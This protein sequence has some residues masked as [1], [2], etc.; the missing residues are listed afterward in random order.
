MKNEGE[1]V[2][3][4]IV[5]MVSFI[6]HVAKCQREPQGTRGLGVQGLRGWVWF[7]ERGTRTV[8]GG[9]MSAVDRRQGGRVLG[10]SLDSMLSV[11][12]K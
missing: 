2:L 4:Q 5:S 1:S 7:V 3:G 6:K 9:H 11:I 10:R 12:G 8:R